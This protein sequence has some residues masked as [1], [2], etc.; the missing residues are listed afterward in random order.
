MKAPGRGERIVLAT[1]NPAKLERLRWLLQGLGLTIL[2]PIAAGDAPAVVE[3][4]ATHQENAAKKAAAYSRRYTCAAIASDGGLVI[5]ALGAAWDPV[6]TKRLERLAP[7]DASDTERIELLLRLMRPCTGEARTAWWEEALALAN[8]GEIVRQW[9][10]E[11][12]KGRIAQTYR[13]D[14]INPGFWAFSLWHI[15]EY[16]KSYVELSISERERLDDHWSRLK[17]Q[18]QAYFVERHGKAT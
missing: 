13:P 6:H 1:T 9:T 16:G 18:V 14:L 4:G 8:R 10:A 11:S 2:P 15:P 12:P 7:A 17:A 5:P 3:D